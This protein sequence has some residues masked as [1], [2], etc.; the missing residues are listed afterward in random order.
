MNNK[1]VNEVTL[2]CGL[3]V[4]MMHKNSFVHCYIVL[5]KT[6]SNLIE[7]N[8]STEQLARGRR[9]AA[10]YHGRTLRPRVW[11]QWSVH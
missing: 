5:R 2:G 8:C 6:Q 9:R 10:V 3:K 1:R 7:G 4:P 11:S